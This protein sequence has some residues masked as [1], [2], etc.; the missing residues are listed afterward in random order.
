[1]SPRRTLNLL[2][3]A[4]GLVFLTGC[5]TE[6]VTDSAFWSYLPFTKK[7]GGSGQGGAAE[8]EPKSGQ[9][10][11]V[12]AKGTNAGQP[13][14]V[15]DPQSEAW[16]EPAPKSNGTTPAEAQ[17][18]TTRLP[19]P[20]EQAP[21]PVATGRGPDCTASEQAR[22]TPLGQVL[23]APYLGDITSKD[24]RGANGLALPVP[25]SPALATPTAGTLHLPVIRDAVPAKDT[26]GLPTLPTIGP[27]AD[28]SASTARRPV[29]PT[30]AKEA[31]RR[32]PRTPISFPT[33]VL[34]GKNTPPD[35]TLPAPEI[36]T[37]SNNANAGAGPGLPPVKGTNGA[38][39]TKAPTDRANGWDG[40]G[41][42]ALGSQQSSPTTKTLPEGLLQDPAAT[43]ASAGNFALT[44][45][46]APGTSGP[47]ISNAPTVS[48]PGAPGNPSTAGGVFTGNLNLGPLA[49]KGPGNMAPL[50]SVGVLAPL[51]PKPIPA[52]FRLSE[53]ISN[54]ALHQAW[55][56]Q[57]AM[58]AQAEP[59][60]R[61]S[62][63]Q[64]LRLVIDR[65]LLNESTESPATK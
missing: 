20:N 58:R 61:G 55:R 21:L 38:D 11:P 27:A 13:L 23:P 64:R 40:L 53:W 28:K 54:D 43:S 57:Q 48:T 47:A 22:V 26:A 3:A 15:K 19:S 51:P 39:G 7:K 46:N 2:V 52:P 14:H 65:F 37:G 6:V 1:M 44:A 12:E 9:P 59:E 10:K 32:A 4:A 8:T 29:L 30:L 35:A 24:P 62:E 34:A 25:P 36:T 33:V 45:P 41:A 5:A 31:E 60:V 63:Q 56:R 42:R 50:P 18:N 16:N 17:P 49:P